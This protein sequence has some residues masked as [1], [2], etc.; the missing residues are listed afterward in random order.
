MQF[1][2]YPSY[3]NVRHD[4]LVNIPNNWNL[5][6]RKFFCKE[7]NIRSIFGNEDLL[8]VSEYYGVKPRSS[9]IGESNFL[10]RAETLEGYKICAKGDLVI[11]IMLAWKRGL[12]VSSFD[13]IVSPA[14]S[15]FRFHS[16]IIDPAI[17]Y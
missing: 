5:I 15:V 4:R 14:Y 7:I 9:V 10:S 12:G 1:K 13:G 2:E 6:K 11:N 16:D 17:K 3:K 8:S